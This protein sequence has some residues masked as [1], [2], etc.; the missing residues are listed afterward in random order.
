MVFEDRGLSA[1]ILFAIGMVS[2]YRT[3]QWTELENNVVFFSR[4][5][6]SGLPADTLHSSS[7]I[8]LTSVLHLLL[9]T[10]RFLVL[11]DIGDNK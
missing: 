2:V 10:W 7:G 11:R 6:T 9:V 8:Y 1:R 3:F 4:H 5:S